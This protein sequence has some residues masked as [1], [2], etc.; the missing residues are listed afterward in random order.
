VAVELAEAEQD[1]TYSPRKKARSARPTQQIPSSEVVQEEDAEPDTNA[2]DGAEE[3][4]PDPERLAVDAEE[5]VEAFKIARTRARRAIER[6]RLHADATTRA[7]L[8]SELIEHG[9]AI[10]ALGQELTAQAQA[11]SQ[12]DAAEQGERQTRPPRRSG[13]KNERK[14]TKKRGRK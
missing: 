14:K 5:V 2:E 12:S 4:Q 3:H 13:T 6:V 11:R 8:G 7:I 9:T 10:L 1:D